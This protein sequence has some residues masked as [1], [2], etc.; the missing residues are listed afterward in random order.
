MSRLSSERFFKGASSHYQQVLFQLRRAFVGRR[1]ARVLERTAQ[2][3]SYEEHLA[4]V[5]LVL[6][7]ARELP[8]RVGQEPLVSLD[9]ALELLRDRRELYRLAHMLS[10]REGEVQVAF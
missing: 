9:G 8:G 3:G 7:L 10:Q 2:A 4:P 6:L 1:G 5:G